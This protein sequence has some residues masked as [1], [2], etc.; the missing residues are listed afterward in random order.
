M[1]LTDF[2]REMAMSH[3]NKT[4]AMRILDRNGVEYRVISYPCK[5][6]ID[7]V[8]VAERLG[9]PVDVVFKTLVTVGKSREYFVFVVP[10][11]EELDLKKAAV[12]VGEKSIEMIPVKDINKVTGYVRGGCSPVGMKKQFVTVFDDSAKTKEKIFV[13]AGRIG[14]QFEVL[15]HDL[16][17]VTDGKFASIT[18]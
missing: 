2:R 12:S 15:P 3:E 4:N 6:A 17:R 8:T 9:A 1:P 5:E 7:G 18:R 11:A 10:A 14:C 16:L 13:S